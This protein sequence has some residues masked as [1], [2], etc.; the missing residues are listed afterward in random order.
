MNKF[1]QNI[2]TINHMGK[3]NNFLT[4][5]QHLKQQ[6]KNNSIIKNKIKTK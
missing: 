4:K 3:S 1:K 5:L 6:M 2:G